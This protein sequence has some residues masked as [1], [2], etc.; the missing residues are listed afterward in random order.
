M[1]LACNGELVL[2]G[3]PLKVE[4]TPSGKLWLTPKLSFPIGVL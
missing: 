4:L 1:Y 3:L 2:R